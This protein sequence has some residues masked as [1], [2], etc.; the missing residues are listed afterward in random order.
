MTKEKLP[1]LNGLRAISILFV[2]FSHT[3]S[4][5]AEIPI[6]KN[7]IN[8]FPFLVDGQLG[9]NVF[10]VISGFLITSLLIKEQEAKNTIS[11]KNFYIRRTLRIFPAYYLM[12][13]VY[14]ILQLTGTL[15][16]S[17]ESWLT[18]ITYT[19]YFNWRL[20]VLTAHA[21]SLSIEEHFY[22]F[23]PLLFSSRKINY[24]IILIGILIICPIF[25]IYGLF[26]QINF[27]DNLTIFQ[28]LDSIVIGCLVALN[29]NKVKEIIA[30]H[31]FLIYLS[32]IWILAYPYLTD[33]TLHFNISKA[34]FV[35]PLTGSSGSITS[36][37]VSILVVFSVFHRENIWFRML[38][39]K[40]MEQIGLISYSLYLWQQIFT[41]ELPFGKNLFPWN[42]L[43]I[44]SVAFLS[45]YAVE[46]PFIKL[47]DK[48]TVK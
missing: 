9:V 35:S 12:L 24:N 48:F 25:R 38:N 36:V 41:S 44:F 33:L 26:H 4:Q 39:L 1:G 7:I 32:F 18:S 8:I 34:Y 27:L 14:F 19:K 22:L 11:L 3:K 17:P 45:F 21:W 30:K 29:I 31:K 28:R 10:F 16:L 2:I 15:Y 43:L 20:D 13:L 40:A 42:Y 37:A 46:R 47:K 5:L 6:I 23:W